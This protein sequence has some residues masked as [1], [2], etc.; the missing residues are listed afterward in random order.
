MRAGAENVGKSAL[1]LLNLADD[2]I[3][4]PK[5]DFWIGFWGGKNHFF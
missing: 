2:L 4:F 3:R 1:A 5:N